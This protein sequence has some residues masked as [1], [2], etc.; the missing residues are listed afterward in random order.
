MYYFICFFA[1][2]VFSR[3]R[4]DAADFN[5]L[6]ELKSEDFEH[7]VGEQGKCS[8]NMLNLCSF[9]SSLHYCLHALI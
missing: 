2:L 9:V 6:Q 1:L 4:I 3:Y 5:D 7:R 8:L